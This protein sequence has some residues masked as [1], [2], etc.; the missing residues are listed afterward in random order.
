[1]VL[2]KIRISIF[3][4]Y[5][6]AIEYTCDPCCKNSERYSK[7]QKIIDRLGSRS[8]EF[9]IGSGYRFKLEKKILCLSLEWERDH[10]KVE[11]K[12]YLFSHPGS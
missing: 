9:W 11:G 4:F 3:F 2:E 6:I 8:R 12:E 10:R 5:L 7:K 1:M